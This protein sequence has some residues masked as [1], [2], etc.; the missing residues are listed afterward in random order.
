MKRPH[1]PL[2]GL[3]ASVLLVYG[4]L[5]LFYRSPLPSLVSESGQ[6]WTRLSLLIGLLR[7]A[8]LWPE[9]LIRSWFQWLEVSCPGFE[10]ELVSR[11]QM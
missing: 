7:Q 6:R 3:I 5:L 9:D 10:I 11:V 4:Y 1:I 2:P 8:A